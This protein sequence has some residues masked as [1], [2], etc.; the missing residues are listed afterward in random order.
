MFVDLLMQP[1]N[2]SRS[3]PSLQHP[4]LT[5]LLTSVAPTLPKTCDNLLNHCGDLLTEALPV[6]VPR[7]TNCCWLLTFY[8]K[9]TEWVESRIIRMFFTTS[10]DHTYPSFRQISLFLRK[11]SIAIFSNRKGRHVDEQE[12]EDRG[13]RIISHAGSGLYRQS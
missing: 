7:L 3:C 9:N 13:N 4:I 11:G 5:G 8:F 6:R 10:L 2:P 12:L 1:G